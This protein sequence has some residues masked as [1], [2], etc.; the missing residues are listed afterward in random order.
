MALTGRTRY[1]TQKR[2][3]REPLLVLQVEEKQ[4]RTENTPGGVDAFGAIVWR[5]AK[6]EDLSELFLIES[7]L[8]DK[9]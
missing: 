5:D 9:A 3:L 7:G 6:V 2:W 4:T 8:K 1:R